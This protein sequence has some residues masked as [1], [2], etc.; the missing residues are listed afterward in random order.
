LLQR[1]VGDPVRAV[2]SIRNALF[3]MAG[4]DGPPSNVE[5]YAIKFTAM[6]SF[7]RARLQQV[8]L[9]EMMRAS[10]QSILSLLEASPKNTKL[11][12]GSEAYFINIL[13]NRLL[14][15]SF[16]R[17]GGLPMGLG[18]F[19]FEIE[20]MRSASEDGA[21]GDIGPT[22]ASWR[23]TIMLRPVWLELRRMEPFLLDLF[24]SA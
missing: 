10:V 7:F 2:S 22:M 11:N 6:R 12:K 19:L 23:R 14:S 5:A 13:K 1:C 15:K 18:L 16:A 3:Q 21:V 4:R 20:L 17:L 9:P 24:M 8:Q